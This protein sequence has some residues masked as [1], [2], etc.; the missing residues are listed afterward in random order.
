MAT[1]EATGYAMDYCDGRRSDSGELRTYHKSDGLARQAKGTWAG[2]PV[3]AKN[4]VREDADA[5]TRR[6]AHE[7][8][9][10]LAFQRQKDYRSRVI[11]SPMRK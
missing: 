9:L 1:D 4:R 8:P 6:P 3:R 7:T 11:R 10:V 2:A 5:Q